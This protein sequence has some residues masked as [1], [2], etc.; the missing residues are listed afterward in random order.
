LGFLGRGVG[1]M[2][3]LCR[4]NAIGDELHGSERALFCPRSSC[5]HRERRA[6]VFCSQCGARLEQNIKE[7]S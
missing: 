1:R 4:S 3:G 7:T 2:L 5:G 6:A